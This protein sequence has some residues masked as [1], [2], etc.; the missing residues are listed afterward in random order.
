ML[1][2]KKKSHLKRY[3]DALTIW[4]SDFAALILNCHRHRY[5]H[6]MTEHIKEPRHLHPR[7]S[8]WWPV[9]KYKPG[10]PLEPGDQQI[11]TRLN[12]LLRDRRLMTAHLFTSAQ[13]WHVFYFDQRDLAPRGENHWEHG[14]HV[15]FANGLWPH[16]SLA[17]VREQ[18]D[19]PRGGIGG[20]FHVRF[21]QSTSG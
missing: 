6:Q 2:F 12:Q 4:S 3:C 7:P 18:L 21:A 8:E 11:L 15:H 14:P 20:T 19:D 10:D 9:G 16:L 13:R 17:G 5:L 1:E